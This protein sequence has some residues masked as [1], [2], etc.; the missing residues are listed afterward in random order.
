MT[1]IR[2]LASESLGWLIGTGILLV[3]A[4]C[5]AI[6]A[7]LAAGLAADTVI[8]VL[9][10]ISGIA[11]FVLSW[12]LRHI[13]GSPWEFLI[14]LVYVAGGLALFAYPVNGLVTL[15][16]VL[17]LYLFGSAITEL[18]AYY[19]LR[20]LAG[21]GWLLFNGIVTLIL[22]VM[23]FRHLPISA[24]WVPGTLVGFALL[25]SGISRLF[26]ASAAKRVATKLNA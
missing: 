17:S 24:V 23:I 7:P 3:L 21:S 15:T 25:S 13:G 4:G 1:N 12:K 18:L 20:F 19:G 5:F 22:A 26:L 11:H 2:S 9:I 16:L 8:A 10:F 6:Y 14:G